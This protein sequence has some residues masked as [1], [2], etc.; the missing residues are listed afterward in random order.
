MGENICKWYHHKWVSMTKYTN[1][2]YNSVS[3]KQTTQSK[4][5][6]KT[7]IDILA[8]KTYRWLIG[9]WRDAQ[10]WWLLEKCKSRQQLYNFTPV[11]MAI[12]RR[13]WHPTPVLLP[14]K[15]HGWRS[16]VGCS[17]WGRSESDTTKRLHFHFSLSCIVEGNGSPLQCSCL[18]NPRDGGAWWAA[19]YGLH[20]VEHDWSDLAGAAA[21]AEWL[22]SESLQI[23]NAGKHVKR[24]KPLYTFGGNVN[25]SSHYGKE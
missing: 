17:P 22:S 25:W 12:R 21:P 7:W 11:R 10:H 9:T 5:G 24:R 3:K 14:G 13:Q 8:K 6:Q 23:T 1:S 19:V 15:Y 4:S 20:R 18:E 16:L 2:S